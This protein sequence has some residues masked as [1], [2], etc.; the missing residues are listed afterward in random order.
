MVMRVVNYVLPGIPDLTQHNRISD[1]PR[2]AV[3]VVCTEDECGQYAAYEGIVLVRGDS[4]LAQDNALE[5]IMSRGRKLNV[6][7]ASQ[8]FTGIADKYRH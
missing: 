6:T 2:P 7:R 5:L 3:C 1:D 4:S 8:H